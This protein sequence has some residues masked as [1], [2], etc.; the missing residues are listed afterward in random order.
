MSSGAGPRHLVVLAADKLDGCRDP[1]FND[2]RK[3]LQAW[4]PREGVLV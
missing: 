4:F 1:A 2:L 3:T